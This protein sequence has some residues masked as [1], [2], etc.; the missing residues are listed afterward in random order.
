MLPP[1]FTPAAMVAWRSYAATQSKPAAWQATTRRQYASGGGADGGGEDG[2][3]GAGEG[4]LVAKAYELMR[5]DY[6]TCRNAVVFLRANEGDADE[7]APP[8]GQS[9]R[10]ARRPQ[11][12][13]P[14][15]E[16]PAPA[17]AESGDGEADAG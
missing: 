11:A 15:G 14:G 9:R 5:R 4:D 8:L 7:I 2:G 1:P 10:R 6:E 3:G 17:P 16:T 13:E 12:D